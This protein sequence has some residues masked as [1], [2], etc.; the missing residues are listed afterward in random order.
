MTEPD[1]QV[2]AVVAAAVDQVW[3]RPIAPADDADPAHRAWRFS[4]RWWHRP[5]PARRERPWTG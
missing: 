2:V 5:V 1:P 4:G 3:P